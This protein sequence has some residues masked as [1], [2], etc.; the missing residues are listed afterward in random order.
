MEL[1]TG[2]KKLLI[3]KA[4]EKIRGREGDNTIVTDSL[5]F[6]FKRGE[7][8]EKNIVEIPLAFRS[9]N[10]PRQREETKKQEIWWL[11]LRRVSALE[12]RHEKQFMNIAIK[13]ALGSIDYLTRLGRRGFFDLRSKVNFKRGDRVAIYEG[14]DAT[15]TV[16][17]GSGSS[18][19]DSYSLLIDPR[20]KLLPEN[21]VARMMD[22][23]RGDRRRIEEAF[24]GP[25][26]DIKPKIFVAH[27]KMSYVMTRI[28]WD[29]TA[30]SKQ[31]F[32][33]FNAKTKEKA[34]MELS[35]KQ[36]FQ[37][38]YQIGISEHDANLPLVEAERM[39]KARR[40]GEKPAK[41]P[42]SLCRLASIAVKD[43]PKDLT[44]RLQ[45]APERVLDSIKKTVKDIKEKLRNFDIEL[46]EK[47]LSLP[48]NKLSELTLEIGT[49]TV[50]VDHTAQWRNALRGRV[51]DEKKK[52]KVLIITSERQP[53]QNRD[54]D[55]ASLG[56]D[57]QTMTRECGGRCADNLCTEAR[58]VYEQTCR[59]FGPPD[60]VLTIFREDDMLYS[61][62]KS[63]FHGQRMPH[64]HMITKTLRKGLSALTKVFLQMYNK[65]GGRPW[66]L[67]VK[68][69]DSKVFNALG[70]TLVCAVDYEKVF[71]SCTLI[72]LVSNKDQYCANFNTKLKKSE[73]GA[74][75][76]IDCATLQELMSATIKDWNT[77]GNPL[78]RS[79][80]IYRPSGGI[81]KLRAP[82]SV[83][84]PTTAAAAGSSSEDA[85]TADGERGR[86]KKPVDHEIE[87]VVKA[88]LENKSCFGGPPRLM[89]VDV[90]KR[91]NEKF[92]LKGSG[93]YVKNV[94]AGTIVRD[95]ITS[96]GD[97]SGSTF[98][99]VS[100]NSGKFM[101]KPVKYEVV[102]TKSRCE[103]IHFDLGSKDAKITDLKLF[104]AKEEGRSYAKAL[105]EVTNI[106]C[107]VYS[108]WS[109]AIRI[110]SIVLC[111]RKAVE[112]QA[113][114]HP[115]GNLS[116]L[117]ASGIAT[118]QKMFMI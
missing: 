108:N 37:Q 52:L 87:A 83:R 82:R 80:I 74:L 39:G 3:H 13:S 64:Q 112:T 9:N 26:K 79:V 45:R 38:K 35:F 62:L 97:A 33:F 41:L 114:I 105:Q 16:L 88:I 2:K 14:F 103:N 30:S 69:M 28:L 107:N 65:Q 115:D 76:G 63:F 100:H 40:E 55:Q 75:F 44:R 99:L 10:D 101:S 98:F 85:K 23:F 53:L 5:Q 68:S 12:L 102:S 81:S 86:E 92:F 7:L 95:T 93:G 67:S 21:N 29:E 54:I 27:N 24:F 50:R 91:P 61:K 117:D 25:A 11:E 109:G 72:G 84:P 42:P 1:S 66:S 56:L 96:N 8:K 94:D 18:K 32:R 43:K 59:E 51:F 49:K 113:A 110:P 15:I 116:Q 46:T 17:E 77:A 118:F 111:A 6:A 34:N 78:I 4:I 71:S 48:V 31:E 36:Y 60:C 70:T 104:D 47:P 20:V 106:Q 19:E 57:V 58:R 22:E 73:D 89:Y 90:N